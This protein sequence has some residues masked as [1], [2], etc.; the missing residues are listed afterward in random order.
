MA[1]AGK[2][3]KVA[4]GTDD[5]VT[6]VGIKNWS[7]ELSTDT[8]ETTALGDDWKNYITGLMEWTASSEGDYSVETDAEGQAALQEAFLA[9]ETVDLKLY[10]DDTHYYSGEAIINSL[11][12]EDPV[13]DV[14]NI[15]IEFTGNG[16]LSF[17]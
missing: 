12:I 9:G 14:V 16:E 17:T 10:V 15:S 4:I 13:D 11:S 5:P 6:V 2:K 1:I 3:G 8:L 7:L